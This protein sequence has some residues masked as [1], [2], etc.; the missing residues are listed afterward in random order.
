[1]RRRSARPSAQRAGGSSGRAAASALRLAHSVGAALGNRRVLD[2]KETTVL[3]WL[4]VPIFLFAIVG[5]IWPR[6]LAW[7]LVV[8][9]AWIGFVLLGRYLRSRRKRTV[10]AAP[11]LPETT[12]GVPPQESRP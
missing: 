11:V 6:V 7:P 8:F 4:V 10:T 9:A 12:D 1:M 3:P 5:A 2:R